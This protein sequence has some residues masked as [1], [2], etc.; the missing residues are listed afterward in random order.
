VLTLLPDASGARLVIHNADGS[1]PEMCGNGAR[2]AALWIATSGCERLPASQGQTV[3]LQTDAGPRPCL[4]WAASPAQG[5]VEVG[6]GPA[7][8]SPARELPLGGRG[9]AALPVSMGNPHRVIALEATRAELLQLAERFGPA[10]CAQEDANIE[11]VAQR[12]PRRWEC[13]VYERGAGLTQACGTGACAVAAAAVFRG[14]ARAGEPVVVELPGGPL[15]ITVSAD[16]S[17]VRMRGPAQLVFRG[18]LP[19]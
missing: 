13:V 18:E 11:L 8:I 7:R 10:L 4:V 19:G 14:Q 3:L 2:A 1:R 15:S 17:E 9:V 16:L 12:G 5:E 6:M